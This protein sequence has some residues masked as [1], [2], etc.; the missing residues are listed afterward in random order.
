M[1]FTDNIIST[2][3]GS[4]SGEEIIQQ[5]ETLTAI[6]LCACQSVWCFY[7]SLTFSLSLFER[8]IDKE[9]ATSTRGESA[10]GQM[11]SVKL[12]SFFH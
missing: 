7:A 12:A 8:H 10:K 2:G 9:L 3:K 1:Y 6:Y 4:V 11:H 5:L